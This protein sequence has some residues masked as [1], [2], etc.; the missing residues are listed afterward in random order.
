MVRLMVEKQRRADRD[1]RIRARVGQIADA[2]NVPTEYFYADTTAQSSAAEANECLRLWF[3]IETPER[4]RRALA[5]LRAL[6]EGEDLA[7]SEGP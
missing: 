1:E 7:E 3:Q 6:A 4:R 2:L 5:L